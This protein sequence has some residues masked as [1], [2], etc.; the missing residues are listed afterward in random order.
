MPTGDLNKFMKNLDDALQNQYKPKAEF[1]MVGDENIDYLTESNGKRQLASILMTQSLSHTVNFAT[2]IQNNLS[3]ANDNVFVDNSRTNLT[4][5]SPITN[6]L[7]DHDAQI[8][9]IRNIYETIHTSPLKQRTRLIDN[10][11]ITNF[12]TLLKQDTWESF[13][14]NKNLIVCLINFYE[15]SSTFSKLVFQ[16]NTKV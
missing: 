15:L 2:R 9:T 4:S 8:L 16:L 6:S 7:S 11:I 12:Q 5:A 10:E 1:L 3:T 14:T 13:S